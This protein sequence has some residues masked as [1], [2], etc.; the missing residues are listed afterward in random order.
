MVLV[1]N[2]RRHVLHPA[3]CCVQL[4]LSVQHMEPL[5]SALS[6]YI[7]EQCKDLIGNDSDTSESDLTVSLTKQFKKLPEDEKVQNLQ[8]IICSY[9]FMT[10]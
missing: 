4:C 8:T 3:W 9:S 7:E 6:Y 1:M 2:L 10:V 5:R